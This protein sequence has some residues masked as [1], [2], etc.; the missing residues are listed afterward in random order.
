LTAGSAAMGGTIDFK[1]CTL[2]Y[3]DGSIFH[4]QC[5][6]GL[7]NGK[8]TMRWHNGDVYEGYYVDNLMHGQG[9]FNHSDDSRYQGQFRANLREGYGVFTFVDG[10]LYEGE[11]RQDQP[12]G[13]GR[14]LYPGGEVLSAG[15]KAGEQDVSSSVPLAPDDKSI[16][17]LMEDPLRG[18]GAKVFP[19]RKAK[20]PPRPPLEPPPPSL[21]ITGG[22]TAQRSLH[23]PLA[24]LGLPAAKPALALAPALEASPE[25]TSLPVLD[26]EMSSSAPLQITAGSSR[27]LPA[28][29]MLTQHSTNVPGAPR[30]P[31]IPAITDGASVPPPPPPKVGGPKRISSLSPIRHSMAS[32]SPHSTLGDR[33]NLGL[34]GG[35]LAAMG[36]PAHPPTAAAVAAIGPP[37]LPA[38]HLP[39]V[40]AGAAIGP[41]PLPAVRSSSSL[42]PIR[43][44]G[45]QTRIPAS[46]VPPPPPP[47]QQNM[48]D[49]REQ[50][51]MVP[52]PPPPL[53]GR[54]NSRDHS[55][56]T[57]LPGTISSLNN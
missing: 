15:F 1:K 53:Q 16:R 33:G 25:Q 52:P 45:G 57:P 37:P 3:E 24:V 18:E 31:V 7:F 26:G 11:W 12:E 22:Q 56:P 51:S 49:S 41:P 27:Q 20:L 42:S 48:Q 10:S 39:T 14:V 47:P 23:G 44:A 50:S 28:L 32:S 6:N 29:P 17:A 5:R 55:S 54:R 9:V 36:P 8:G 19:D 2:E 4:G 38:A 35:S 21:A 34:A 43:T 40:A 13:Q 46:T 30:L